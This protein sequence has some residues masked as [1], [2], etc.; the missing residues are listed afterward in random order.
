[1]ALADGRNDV[2]EWR[3]HFHVP[4]FVDQ[5]TDCASTQPFLKE[6]LPLFGPDIP[7]EVET[8]TWT[9]LPPDL[10]TA[11][12]IESIVREIEWVKTER[13]QA[14]SSPGAEGGG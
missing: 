10:R 5:L 4:V 13:E 1:M 12:V 14:A 7:L 3:V 9:V 6:I 2:E 11:T 8:Y